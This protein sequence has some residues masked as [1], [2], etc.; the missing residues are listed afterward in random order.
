MVVA[1]AE[2]RAASPLA[3][4]EQRVQRRAKDLDVEVGPAGAAVLRRLVDEAVAEWQRDH[5]RGLHELPLADPDLI[6]DRAVRNL[7]GYGPLEPLLAD[8]DV[9]EIMVNGPTGS[10]GSS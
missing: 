8:D 9:W 10:L 4:I 2:R 3:V 5:E 6:A 1:S 7:T